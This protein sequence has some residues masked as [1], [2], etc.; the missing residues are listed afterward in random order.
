MSNVRVWG[1]RGN[2]GCAAIFCFDGSANFPPDIFW[3]LILW[4]RNLF[5]F[6]NYVFFKKI[7]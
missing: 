7:L 2:V 3:F 6:E 4:Q 5:L 1:V